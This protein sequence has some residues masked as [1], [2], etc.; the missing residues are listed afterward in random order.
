MLPDAV[1]RYMEDVHDQHGPPMIVPQDEHSND[2]TEVRFDGGPTLMVKRSRSYPE[3]AVA[4]FS[5]CRSA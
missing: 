3:S 5:T 4:R 2:L 1:L